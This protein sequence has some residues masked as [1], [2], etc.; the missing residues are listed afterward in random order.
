M[1]SQSSSSPDAASFNLWIDQVRVKMVSA[2]FTLAEAQQDIDT[3]PLWYARKFRDGFSATDTAYQAGSW[4]AE[5]DAAVPFDQWLEQVRAE[6]VNIVSTPE[7]AQQDIAAR[8][9][10]YAAQFNLGRSVQE[11]AERATGH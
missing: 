10:W 2:V 9:A 7:D 1:S 4:P 11:A 8:R 5:R 3:R 6:M